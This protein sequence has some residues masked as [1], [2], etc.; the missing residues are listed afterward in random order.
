MSPVDS[1]RG[2]DELARAAQAV[3][4]SQ[5][6]YDAA[7]KAPAE[8]LSLAWHDVSRARMALR[9]TLEDRAHNQGL[10]PGGKSRRCPCTACAEICDG[11]PAPAEERRR[12]LRARTAARSLSRSERPSGQLNG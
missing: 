10:E 6:R 11:D 3:L 1:P 12:D 2:A 9:H 7:R 4:D 8:E 5:E